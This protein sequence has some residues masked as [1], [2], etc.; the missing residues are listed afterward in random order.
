MQ[1]EAGLTEVMRVPSSN[2]VYF[3]ASQGIFPLVER[4]VIGSKLPGMVLPEQRP[5]DFRI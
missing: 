1:E 4:L 3:A 2:W 5:I